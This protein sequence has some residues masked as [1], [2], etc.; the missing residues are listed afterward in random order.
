MLLQIYDVYFTKKVI[1]DQN[2]CYYYNM[3]D[4]DH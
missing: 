4:N 1:H 3:S 2:Y